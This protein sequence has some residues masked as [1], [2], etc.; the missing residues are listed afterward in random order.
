M[1]DDDEDNVVQHPAAILA[2]GIPVD[3]VMRSLELGDNAPVA[4]EQGGKQL[5]WGG[6]GC[7]HDGHQVLVDLDRRTLTCGHC[8]GAVDPLAFIAKL[9]REWERI[10]GW[11]RH[12]RNERARHEDEIAKLKRESSK[13]RADVQKQRDLLE[14]MKIDPPTQAEATRQARA[15]RKRRR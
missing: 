12:A 1:M 5:A 2:T 3:F 11:E 6:D 9:S 13:L 7:R 4:R 15:Q 14:A 10:K 8:R